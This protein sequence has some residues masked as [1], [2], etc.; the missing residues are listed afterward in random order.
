[1]IFPPPLAFSSGPSLCSL[2]LLKIELLQRSPERDRLEKCGGGFKLASE[3]RQR[4]MKPNSKSSPIGDLP[5][6]LSP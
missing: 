3:R 5:F 2:P 4:C 1:M 6:A